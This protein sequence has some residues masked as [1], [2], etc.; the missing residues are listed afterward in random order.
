M[1]VNV[2][3]KVTKHDGDEILQGEVQSA[4]RSAREMVRE[5]LKHMGEDD[6][7]DFEVVH[8]KIEE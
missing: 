6:E 7:F 1:L 5:A 4:V 8:A 3:L 2:V